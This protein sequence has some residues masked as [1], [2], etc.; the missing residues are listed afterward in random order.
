DRLTLAAD[1]ASDALWEWDVRTKE[2]YVSP[3]W[4][5]L[6]GLPDTADVSRIGDWIDRVH[7]D[8]AA[9]LN[10]AIKAALEGQTTSLQHEHPIR[11]EDGSYRWF[12]CSGLRGSGRRATRIGGSLGDIT[13]QIATQE[14]LRTAA[15]LD[16]LTGL[17][18]RADF[19]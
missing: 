2:L 18:N 13:D 6:I 5:T 1:G 14:R 9:A 12:L 10:E 3:R 8:D 7:G 19:I 15:F 17:R 16:P 11:H 4:K